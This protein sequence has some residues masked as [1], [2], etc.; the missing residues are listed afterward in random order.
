M[1]SAEGVE[2]LHRPAAEASA[3]G[4]SMGH[5]AMGWFVEEHGETTI[6]THPGTVPDFFA[7]MALVPGQN[8]GMV[9]LINANHLIMDKL[10]F[11]DMGL[12]VALRL[13]GEKAPSTGWYGVV[14]WAL[15]GLLLIPVLQVVGAAFTLRRIRR[16][17]QAMDRRPSGA[18]KWALHILL[19]LI[20]NLALVALPLSLLAS[21]LLEFMRLFMP[22]FTWLSLICGGFAAFWVMLRS[23]LVFMTLRRPRESHVPM[24]EFGAAQSPARQG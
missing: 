24:P 9:L 19:P 10:P 3:M 22:D 18:R 2:E 11:T 23:W 14:P 5:Y 20:P 13:A 1:L 16:W 15:R 4:I 8:K 7:F 12:G 21:G 6:L 17:R